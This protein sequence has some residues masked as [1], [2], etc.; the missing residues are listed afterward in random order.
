MGRRKARSKRATRESAAE[1]SRQRQTVQG[2]LQCEGKSGRYA[3]EAEAS[4]AA[5]WVKAQDPSALQMSPYR[6]QYCG[7]WHLTRR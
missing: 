1:A 2:Q 4:R 7:K 3:T 5:G 6:C